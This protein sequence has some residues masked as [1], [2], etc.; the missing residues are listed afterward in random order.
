[1]RLTSREKEIVEILRK[2]PLISQDDL[3]FRFGITRSSVAVHISNLMK[4]G[5]LLG[6]GYVFNEQVS[7]VVVG[8]SCL[9]INIIRDDQQDNI[10]V[11]D[12][13][14][15][16]VISEALNK[17]GIKVKLI[18]VLGN[19]DVAVRLLKRLQ[20]K[21]IDINNIYRDPGRRTC[22]RVWIDN[23]LAYREGYSQ[24][25]YENVINAKS[26]IAFNCEWL[27]VED[28]FHELLNL[29]LINREQEKVPRLC[30]Y[31]S[32]SYPQDIPAILGN[33]DLVV[34]ELNS[35][36]QIDYYINQ[37]KNM[38]QKDRQ[39]F[40][41]TDGTNCIVCVNSLGVND[42]PLL[43]NQNFKGRESLY[44]FLAGIIY[45]L[46]AG[47]TLRQAFRIGTGTASAN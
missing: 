42:Y 45:G 35:Y 24:E 7:M 6:K 10:N 37:L 19:D 2:E 28:Q 23:V 12:G 44:L 11:Q 17:F 4:K 9:E 46:S 32:V 43:P 14:F 30:T 8:E 25:E 3:A 27:I 38:V 22:R 15:I 16:T 21:D 20:S 41:V 13:G 39:N 5:V 40:I 29:K 31:K 34:I 18:S 36:H 26:W 33:Y 1:M 47:Y